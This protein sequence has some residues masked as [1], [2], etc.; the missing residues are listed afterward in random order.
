M[1]AV[2][3]LGSLVACVHANMIKV[4]PRG[5]IMV[6]PSSRESFPGGSK[7]I[8]NIGRY[9]RPGEA[10]GGIVI[11]WEQAGLGLGFYC[12]WHSARG[13]AFGIIF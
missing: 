11:G 3:L 7:C 10:P 13:S 1:L 9:L 4:S 12:S 2:P 5:K 6:C 8:R